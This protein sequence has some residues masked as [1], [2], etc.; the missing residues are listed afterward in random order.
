MN[1]P[2]RIAFYGTL[3]RGEAGYHQLGL[4]KEL[5]FL[6]TGGVP[7][8][9]YDLGPYPALVRGEGVVVAELF[10]V[11]DDRILKALDHF[12]GFDPMNPETSLFVRRETN[13]TDGS[14]VAWVYY[15]GAGERLPAGAMLI[16]SGDWLRH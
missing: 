10:E 1:R 11:P 12:E 13:L 9:L 3:R 8:L 7:G 4:A 15:F 16:P 5:R 6:G 2:S 14:G